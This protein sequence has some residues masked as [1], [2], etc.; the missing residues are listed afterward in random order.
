MAVETLIVDEADDLATLHWLPAL[1]SQLIQVPIDGVDRGLVGE[2][3]LAD[4]D[5]ALGPGIESGDDDP[6]GDS[7]YGII[8]RAAP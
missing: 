7:V 4:D 2:Q 1:H 6:I 3:M 5:L 8:G